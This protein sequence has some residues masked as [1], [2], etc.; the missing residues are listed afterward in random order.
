MASN[1]RKKQVEILPDNS[2]LF[3]EHIAAAVKGLEKAIHLCQRL[4]KNGDQSLSN[5]MRLELT[6]RAHELVSALPRLTGQFP[7]EEEGPSPHYI[8]T[9]T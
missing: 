4:E 8:E 7:A 2:N 3:K 6:L 1:T 9:M 5:Q